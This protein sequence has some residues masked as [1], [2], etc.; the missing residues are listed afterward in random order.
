LTEIAKAGFEFMEIFAPE[1]QLFLAQ[2]KFKMNIIVK[3]LGFLAIG[4]LLA[5]NDAS[6]QT[7][8]VG[9]PVLKYYTSIGG[10]A[11]GCYPNAEFQ[12]TFPTSNVSGVGHYLAVT[13]VPAG[14]FIVQP[15]NDTIAVGDTL[16]MSPPINTYSVYSPTGSGQV[17][18]DIIAKGTPTTA[19][20]PYPC[21]AS[22][23]WI[24]NMMLCPA[25][26]T[27]NVSFSCTVQAGSTGIEESVLNNIAIQFPGGNNG[28]TLMVNGNCKEVSVVDVSGRILYSS[29][30]SSETSYNMSSVPEGIYLLKIL[31]EKGEATKKFSVY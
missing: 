5:S 26:Y 3:T 22:Q 1:T 24:N 19:G 17:L 20:Q 14:V 8:T 31:T 2:N 18:F 13:A 10:Y 7:W 29:K 27:Q 23:F 15:L 16:L 28:Q 4:T 25:G 30:N 6:A 9:Q 12:F 11:G 21:S